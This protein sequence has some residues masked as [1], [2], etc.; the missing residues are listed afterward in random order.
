MNTGITFQ[1]KILN[2]LRDIYSIVTSL[3]NWM[4]K[5]MKKNIKYYIAYLA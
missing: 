2:I 4:G 5:L 3:F 1:N